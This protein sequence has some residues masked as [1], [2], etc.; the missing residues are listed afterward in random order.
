MIPLVPPPCDGEG[1]ARCI[2]EAT[3]VDPLRARDN[4]MNAGSTTPPGPAGRD[5]GTEVPY[6]DSR[7]EED[8]LE[9]RSWSSDR[10]ASDNDDDAC[11]LCKSCGC[12][13]TGAAR[14]GTGGGNAEP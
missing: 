11:C 8:T 7:D 5:D 1:E 10:R 12:K 9:A 3:F 13:G 4:E 6:T 14:G 2:P